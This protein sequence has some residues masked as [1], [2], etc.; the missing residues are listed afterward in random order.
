MDFVLP[1]IMFGLRCLVLLIVGVLI[2]GC[3]KTLAQYGFTWVATRLNRDR[4]PT[5]AQVRGG[6][7]APLRTFR[8]APVLSADSGRHFRPAKLN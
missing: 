6:R 4:S 8:R 7:L 5:I 3:A 1:M 2:V